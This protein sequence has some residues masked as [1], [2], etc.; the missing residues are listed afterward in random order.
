MV[1]RTFQPPPHVALALTD[2]SSVR[3][4]R[5]AVAALFVDSPS[6]DWHADA[7]L[8]VSELVTN[9]L[10]ASGECHLSAWYDSTVNA[11]RVE[12]IDV[13]RNMPAIQPTDST[14]VG[15]HGLRIVEALS[16]RWGVID[17]SDWKA[18]WFEID[19]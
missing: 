12:V 14:R 17:G 18:V 6:M 19:G 7:L 2:A 3:T 16:S 1:P 13:S 10:Q 5:R 9:A 15:G 8:V 4:A 11:L